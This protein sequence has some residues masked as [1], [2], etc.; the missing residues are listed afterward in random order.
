MG[1]CLSF[2]F[3]VL[4]VRGQFLA[5][6]CGG[7]IAD[8]VTTGQHDH[9]GFFESAPRFRGWFP[10]GHAPVMYQ[11]Q[12]DGVQTPGHHWKH[13][14]RDKSDIQMVDGRLPPKNYCGIGR[15]AG[16]GHLVAR[17]DEC[18]WSGLGLLV[19]GLSVYEYIS[20]FPGIAM[21]A[22]SRPKSTKLG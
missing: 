16:L 13:D 9:R 22:S 18:Q 15:S 19:V 11:K 7:G 8:I 21:L 1:S 20:Q 10:G 17:G 3:V 4:C 12:L 5:L 6:S 2:L 14:L